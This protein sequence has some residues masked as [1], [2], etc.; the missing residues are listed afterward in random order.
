MDQTCNSY[1]K[2]TGPSEWRP[3]VH[4][5]LI[6]ID[7]IH[8]TKELNK[9]NQMKTVENNANIQI[10]FMFETNLAEPL[11]PLLLTWLFVLFSL[12]LILLN[13]YINHFKKWTWFYNT[14]N[15]IW[16]NITSNLQQKCTHMW[17]RGWPTIKTWMKTSNIAQYY[18]HSTCSH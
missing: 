4:G 6:L 13:Y 10:V 5:W 8:T 2:S 3:E 1:D 16:W 14:C 18:L 12:L 9:N 11:F 17:K 7:K 15:C